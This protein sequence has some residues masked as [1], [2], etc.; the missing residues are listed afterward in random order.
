MFLA[1]SEASTMASLPRRAQPT[2]QPDKGAN[3]DRKSCYGLSRRASIV[4]VPPA[5]LDDADNNH[6][7]FTMF[8]PVHCTWMTI[9]TM[10][11]TGL[12]CITLCM[13]HAAGDRGNDNM[14]AASIP[15]ME[16]VTALRLMHTYVL[17][18]HD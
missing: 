9:T 1:D 2:P 12:Q 13:P 15:H 17:P 10:M 18:R 6:D 14:H 4:V 8:H 3:P 5:G 11:M 16:Q 7:R